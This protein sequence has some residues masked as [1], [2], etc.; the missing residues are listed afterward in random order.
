MIIIDLVSIVI[1]YVTIG[2]T[3]GVILLVLARVIVNYADLNPFSRTA[4]NVRQFSDPL[5]NPVRRFLIA[6]GLDQKIAPFVTILIAILI[7]LLATGDVRIRVF[8]VAR[9]VHQLAA[10][11]HSVAIRLCPIRRSCRLFPVNRG[12]DPVF[13]GYELWKPH[14]AFSGE[15]D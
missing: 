5:V 8:H 6:Y 4:L 15:S 2:A 14:D 9:C 13:L 7:G 10:R 1:R 11:R 3:V 12:A